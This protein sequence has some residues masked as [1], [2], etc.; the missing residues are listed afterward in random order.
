MPE[1]E[2]KCIE[3]KSFQSKMAIINAYSNIENEYK[4]HTEKI[5]VRMEEFQDR[6]SG[7]TLLH[8]IRLEMNINQ[9]SHFRGSSYIKLPSYLEAKKAIIKVKNI[10]DEY[11][12]KWS[13]IAALSNLNKNASRFTTYIDNINDEL[14]QVNGIT[15]NFTGLEFPLKPT[16]ISKFMEINKDRNVTLFGFDDR[17]IFGPIFYSPEVRT[18]SINMLILEEGCKAHYT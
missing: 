11:C 3:I 13:L 2:K 14:I 4:E 18:N 9:Y 10:N 17:V 1:E 15:L 5:L 8:L 12:F 6:D 7:W 16:D